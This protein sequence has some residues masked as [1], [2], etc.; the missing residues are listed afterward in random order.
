MFP[1]IT[2][3]VALVLLSVNSVLFLFYNDDSLE[4]KSP[5]VSLR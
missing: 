1:T 3:M 4:E 2:I 5:D